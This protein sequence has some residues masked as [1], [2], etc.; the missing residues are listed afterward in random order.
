MSYEVGFTEPA[1]K[2]LGKLEKVMQDR[3]IAALERIRIRPGAYVSKLVGDVSYKLRVGDYRIL[4]EI[5]WTEQRILVH[6]VAHR[7]NVYDF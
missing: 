3:I 7:K 6:K 5:D 4:M 1:K 2:Q